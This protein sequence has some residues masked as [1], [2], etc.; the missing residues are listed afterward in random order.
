MFESGKAEL[1]A[2]AA[3]AVKAVA[4]FL[5][6]NAGAKAQLSG[7]VDA[8]GPADV[9]KELAKK[10]AVAVRDALTAAGVS[11]YILPKKAAGRARPGSSP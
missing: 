4:D 6:A 11:P 2:D 9:N 1:A 5:A 7:F 10:R 8:T 3:P